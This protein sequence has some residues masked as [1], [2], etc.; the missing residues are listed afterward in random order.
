MKTIVV[1]SPEV[2]KWVA[3][4]DAL[5]RQCQMDVVQA[6]TGEEAIAVVQEK[7]PVAVVIDQDLIDM[8]GIDLVRQLLHVN[9]FINVA[10]VS[11]QDEDAFHEETEGLGILMQ[12]KPFPDGQAAAKLCECLMGVI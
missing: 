4:T 11:D 9:A 6:R 7:K 2:E 1:V 12:L 5:G 10:M 8:S 3:F